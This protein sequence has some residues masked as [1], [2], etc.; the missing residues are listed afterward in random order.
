MTLHLTTAAA[1]ALPRNFA[2]KAT[3]SG[4]SLTVEMPTHIYTPGKME[5]QDGV[6][7]GIRGIVSGMITVNDDGTA[8][9]IVG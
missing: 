6:V 2:M 1:N 8:S 4:Y 5:I 9:F 3:L 7:N